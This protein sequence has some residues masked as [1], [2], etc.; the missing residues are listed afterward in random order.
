MTETV[1][2]VAFNATA[3]HSSFF[4]DQGFYL[5]IEQFRVLDQRFSLNLLLGAH[6]IAFAREKNVYARFGAPQGVEMVYRDFISRYYNL[7]MGGFVYPPIQGKSYYNL[8]LRWGTRG[9]F[10]EI[11]YLAWREP[12]GS[13][14]LTTSSVGISLGF[15]LAQFF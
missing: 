8:W 6:A 10:G 15:P 1:R 9:L 2:A 4:T 5:L 12:F 14:S 13:E 7:S 11:N 3:I